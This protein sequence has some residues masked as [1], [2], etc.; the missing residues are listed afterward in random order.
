[1]VGNEVAEVFD[2]G[3]VGAG[4]L[5][6]WEGGVVRGARMMGWGPRGA[7]WVVEAVAWRG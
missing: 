4:L 2:G 1:V 7:V 6:L 5:F 3:R